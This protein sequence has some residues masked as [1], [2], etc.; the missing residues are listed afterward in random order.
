MKISDSSQKAQQIPRQSQACS[1]GNHDGVPGSY[2]QGQHDNV[3]AGDGHT[4]KIRGSFDN[5][6]SAT[7]RSQFEISSSNEWIGRGER[8]ADVDPAS[9]GS[10][11]FAAGQTF[12]ATLFPASSRQ[13]PYEFNQEVNFVE[14]SQPIK[15]VG[16]AKGAS[17]QGNYPYAP[18]QASFDQRT[19]SPVRQPWGPASRSPAQPR[20][21]S[22]QHVGE[23]VFTHNIAQAM[24]AISSL[25]NKLSSSVFG[26]AGEP[27]ERGVPSQFATVD[28]YNQDPTSGDSLMSVQLEESF[29]V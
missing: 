21:V 23:P 26:A 22:Q 11:L 6:G 17:T 18:V 27:A 3:S 25:T 8:A 14:N 5:D 2:A 7:N 10:G 29:S 16:S 24:T 19:A 1:G 4:T 13:N 12:I 15:M 28:P 9:A 20:S